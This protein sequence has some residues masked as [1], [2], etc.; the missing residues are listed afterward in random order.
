[1]NANFDYPTVKKDDI[2]VLYDRNM[3]RLIGKKPEINLG[4][5][6]D[7]DGTMY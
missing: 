5:L 4:R 1:M 2:K 7:V 6:T 3:V